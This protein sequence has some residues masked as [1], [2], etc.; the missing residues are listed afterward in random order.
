[1]NSESQPAPLMQIAE[2]AVVTC[3]S[4]AF[5]HPVPKHSPDY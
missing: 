3:P 1:L 4:Q 2:T 5:R